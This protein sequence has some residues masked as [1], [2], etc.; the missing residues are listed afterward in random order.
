MRLISV[1]RVTSVCALAALAEVL[2]DNAIAPLLPEL[3]DRLGLSQTLAGV[4]VATSG[5]AYMLGAYPALRFASTVGPRATALIGMG[6][7]VAGTLTFAENSSIAVLIAGRALAGFGSVVIYTG[8]V[9]VGVAFAGSAN[10][11]ATIGTIYSGFYAGSALAPFVGAAAV[12]F[13]RGPVFVLLGAAQLAIAG[14]VARL[15]PVPA[16]PTA[17]IGGL[18]G[19]LL[20]GRVRLGLWV[21]SLGPFGL[22]ALVVSGSHRIAEAG[23]TPLSIAVAFGGIAVVNAVS[24][25]VVGR[26]SDQRGRGLPLFALMLLAAVVLVIL[27]PIQDRILLIVLI[28][29]G[30]ALF[31]LVGGPG[32]A[33]VGDAVESLGGND[34]EATF[35]MNLFN[36]PAAALGAILGGV[37]HGAAGGGLPFGMLAAVAA[38][39]AGVIYR[40][41]R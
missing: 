7:V 12:A 30:G 13:G 40:H 3:E 24:A 25:P 20:D 5:I 28:V 33:V 8:V 32:F 11:G 4:L 38:L 17:T 27:V 9:A 23:G 21:A 34:A 2:F 15:P 10:R 6:C 19:Y 39:S 29:V 35:L 26:V 41:L 18:F 16:E 22:G 14:L 31:T 36:G 37:L 1:R